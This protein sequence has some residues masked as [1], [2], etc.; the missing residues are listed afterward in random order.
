MVM[1]KSW[2]ITLF[3]P[4]KVC[5]T[6]H[7]QCSK[8][9]SGT[10]KSLQNFQSTLY[11]SES[12]HVLPGVDIP[13]GEVPHSVCVI[14]RPS[15]RIVQSVSTHVK[16]SFPLAIVPHVHRYQITIGSILL[17]TVA[18]T[19]VQPYEYLLALDEHAYLPF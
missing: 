19:D 12:P 3:T 18:I 6:C 9:H 8:Y 1:T 17:F 5:I 10:S 16:I 15:L 11:S 13:G 7:F 14:K 4:I 2:N